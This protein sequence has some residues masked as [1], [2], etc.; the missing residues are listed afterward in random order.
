MYFIVPDVQTKS[1]IENTLLVP[2][3]R[4]RLMICRLVS[5]ELELELSTRVEDVPTSTG[6]MH[7]K[8]SIDLSPTS[9]SAKQ[10][11]IGIL[12]V[13]IA[14]SLFEVVELVVDFETKLLEFTVDTSQV[15]L[16]MVE[17]FVKVSM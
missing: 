14:V 1:E 11:D 13:S 15:I 12:L 5:S 4:H 10:L 16:L 9:L 3:Y 7:F 8:V 17:P 6:D 2:K